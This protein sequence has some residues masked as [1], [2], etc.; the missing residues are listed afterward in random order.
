MRQRRLAA[1]AVVMGLCNGAKI[2]LQLGLAPALAHLLGPANYGLYSLAQPTIMFVM[3]LADA[4][5]GQS[6]AREPEDN[7]LV[8]SSAFWLLLALGLVLGICVAL[9]S[10]PLAII[11]RQP[12]LP[13]VMA[14][15]SVS[16]ILLTLTIAPSARLTRRGRIEVFAL[17]DLLANLLAGGLALGLAFSGAGVWALVG[18]MLALYGLRAIALNLCAFSAPRFEFSWRAVAPHTLLG[19]GIVAA[20]FADGLGRMLEAGIVGRRFSAAGLGMY[21][22]TNQAA[23][24][25]VQGVANP[26]GTMLYAHAVSADDQSEVRALYLRLLRITALLTLPAT[27]VIAALSWRLTGLLLGSAW[28]TGALVIAVVFPTQA[29]GTLGQLVSAAIYARGWARSQLLLA[30]ANAGL[31]LAAV[32]IPFGGWSALPLYVGAAN[33][34][35]GVLA[36]LIARQQLNWRVRE[37]LSLVWGPAVAAAIAAGGAY[38]V[39]AHTPQSMIWLIFAA[40]A[41]API[42]VI[43]LVL[44]DRRR[45]ADDWDRLRGSVFRRKPAELSQSVPPL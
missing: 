12:G 24:S 41:A 30:F 2:A 33:V 40:V 39:A 17:A 11:S 34:V 21:A 38:T 13:P 6:L 42:Y 3:M 20:K 44:I 14:A 9:W 35:Y 32:A 7:H 5:L 26:T 1:S 45:A 23:W 15:L 43:A 27:A 10:A 4:G 16:V 8:W 25:L 37:A 19:G 22:F 31:R 28:A 36:L 18:Q 29:L